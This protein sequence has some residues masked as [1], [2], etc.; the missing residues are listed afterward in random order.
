MAKLYELIDDLNKIQD[1]IDDPECEVSAECLEDTFESLDFE[2]SEKIE[3]YCKLVKN[4]KS[5]IDQIAIEAKRLATK[6]KAL[7]NKLGNLKQSVAYAMIQTNRAKM[8]TPLFSLYGLKT[9]KLDIT[10]KEVPDEY[11]KERVTKEADKVKIKEALDN[12]EVLSFARYIPSV[13]IR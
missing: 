9:D 6:K 12:G 7:E 10:D 13:T 11:K 3:M 4:V 2:F 5:S 1:M 8:K